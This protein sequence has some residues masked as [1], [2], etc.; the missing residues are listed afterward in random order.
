[1]KRTTWVWLLLGIV[2]GSSWLFIKLGLEDVPP[3]TLAGLRF[4]LASLLMWGY[5]AIRR[6]RL[7]RARRDWALMIGTGLLTFG[8]DYGLVF[9]GESHI[10]A[11]L[12]SILFSTMP[13]FVLLLAHFMVPAERMTR[14]KL[15]G[16]LI[17]I[18]GVALIFSRQLQGSDSLALWGTAAV[19]VAAGLEAVSSVFIRRFGGHLNPAALTT[20][21]MSVG[22][23]PLLAIGVIFEGSPFRFEWTP[24]AW[25]SLLYM[26]LIGSALGFVLLYW[27]LK[28]IGAVRSGLLIPFS[29]VVA[30]LLGVFVLNEAFTWR[31][32]VGGLLVIAGLLAASHGR[33]VGTSADRSSAG[34]P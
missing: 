9:W 14:R 8:V 23:V 6:I 25:A 33:R 10:S 27:L 29:T 17:G 11:G 26:A 13:L 19:L 2:W 3:F 21:Q 24:M 30:V 7:P 18:G 31:T 4:L 12:T 15:V 20:I 16:I 1:M 22:F 5:V 28:R 32:A 34:E